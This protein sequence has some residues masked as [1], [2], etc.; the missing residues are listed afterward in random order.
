MEDIKGP[1]PFF[2]EKITLSKRK[3]ALI[4]AGV[5]LIRALLTLL[6]SYEI[7]M[8]GYRAW[9]LYLA[10]HGYAGFYRTFH[11]V[12]G[13]VIPYLLQL[14]GILAKTFSLCSHAHAYL[15]KLWAVLSDLAGATVLCLLGRRSGRMRRG[16]LLGVAY[17]LNP[18]VFLTHLS[19]GSL[20][21]SPPLYSWAFCI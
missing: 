19:G 8:N 4:I 15:I 2:E 17:L 1:K 13:P 3:S 21:R 16:F 7:D 10:D 20:I 18:A 6:P 5:L 12:Y 9:S 14:S 11:V